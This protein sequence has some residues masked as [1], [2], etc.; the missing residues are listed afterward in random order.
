MRPDSQ[1]RTKVKMLAVYSEERALGWVLNLKK[2]K[3][4]L[5]RNHA[6]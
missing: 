3:K 2:K 4:N 6:Y 1:N 5:L